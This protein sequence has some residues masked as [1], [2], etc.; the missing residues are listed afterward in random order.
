VLERILLSVS[1]DEAL[2]IATM[3]HLVFEQT[4]MTMFA[5]LRETPMESLPQLEYALLT[6]ARV[7]L[8]NI[9]RPDYVALVRVLIAEIP[10]F[11]S[12]GSLFFS[13]LPQEGGSI[14]KA[15]LE[16]ALAQG[17]IASVDLEAATQL[18]V[19]SLL[20]YIIGALVR[21]ESSLQPPPPERVATLVRLFLHGVACHTRQETG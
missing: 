4:S 15:L 16:S 10:R 20:M 21:P 5:A 17:V 7:M 8:E 14:V 2:F 9:M 1:C 19:G 13:V 18:F 3:Q 11:P 12:L 6:W